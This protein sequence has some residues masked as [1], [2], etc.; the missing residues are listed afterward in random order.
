MRACREAAP[1]AAAAAALPKADKSTTTIHFLAVTA[2]PAALTWP[3]LVSSLRN[4]HTVAA[5]VAAAAAAAVAAVA[6][7]VEEGARACAESAHQDPSARREGRSERG[8]EMA[9][10][11]DKCVKCALMQLTQDH[12]SKVSWPQ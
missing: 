11:R 12:R 2:A 6:A 5:A 1:A 8:G 9:I 10:W 7:A 3:C 4:G